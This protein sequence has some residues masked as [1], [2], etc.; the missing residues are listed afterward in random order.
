MIDLQ[1][2]PVITSEGVR[3]I[4]ADCKSAKRL[5]HYIGNPGEVVTY[6]FKHHSNTDPIRFKSIK[7]AVESIATTLGNNVTIMDYY[8]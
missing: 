5:R 7:K 6:D 1:I 2:I 8:P 4:V 3:Y